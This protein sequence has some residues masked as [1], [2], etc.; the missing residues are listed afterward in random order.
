MVPRGDLELFSSRAGDRLRPPRRSS[1]TSAAWPW[2]RTSR[3]SCELDLPGSKWWSARARARRLSAP[4]T[5]RSVTSASSTSRS[6]PQVYAGADVF[7]FP[8][9][10]DTFGLVLLEAMACGL[11]V[12]A[13]PVTG[14]LDVI[15]APGAGAMHED[16]RTACLE[17]L[18]IDRA[19]ARK[20]AEALSWREPPSSSSGSCIP[21]PTCG[22]AGNATVTA[23]IKK[24]IDAPSPWR[25]ICFRLRSAQLG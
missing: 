25:S 20:H 14:P 3:P 9:K 6:S 11:P 13:Y 18:K 15:G 4:G 19:T 21:S 1:S 7:V 8:S 5:R 23:L 12:A 22:W 24:P 10:T 16:L 2:R 17:A